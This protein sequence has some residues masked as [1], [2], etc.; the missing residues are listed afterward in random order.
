MHIEHKI[1]RRRGLALASGLAVVACFG[2]TSLDEGAKIDTTRGVLEK[3]IETRKLVSQEK[4]DWAEGK[5]TL[6]QR[7][8]LVEREIASLR[9]RIQSAE[10]SI[11]EADRGRAELIGQNDGLKASSNVLEGA[12][13]GLEQR[14]RE[15]LVRLPEPIR[16]RVRPLSQR[17]PEPE[18]KIEVGLS[19]RFQNLVGI[20]N[21]VDKFNRALT[22][23]SEVRDL[24]GGAAAEVDTLYVGLGQGYYVNASNT[25]AGIGTSTAEGWA[26]TP[27][28]EAALQIREALRVLSNERLADFIQL[29]IR[30]VR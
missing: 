1:F 14:L 10:G 19:D 11:A 27:A 12:A 7:I 24:E 21:E 6:E 18:A 8:E 4:R 22:V 26:W 23:L 16:E 28:N 2:L 25:T 29:P 17:L 20:L 3:W 9:E 15:L 5:E 30:I 13:A